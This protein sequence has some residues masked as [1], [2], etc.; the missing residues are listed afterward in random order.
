MQLKV[1]EIRPKDGKLRFAFW[2]GLPIKTAE[3]KRHDALGADPSAPS[4]IQIDASL[5][6][7]R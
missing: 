7:A 3:G 5:M 4:R 6:K 2:P 1:F